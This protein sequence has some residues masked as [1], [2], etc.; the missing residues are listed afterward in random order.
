MPLHRI[1]HHGRPAYRWGKSG[2]PYTYTAGNKKSRARAK[3]MAIKQGLAIEYSEH[4]GK[5]PKHFRP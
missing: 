5:R 1:Q 2:H 3:R 4:Y